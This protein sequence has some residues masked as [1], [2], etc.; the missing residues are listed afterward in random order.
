MRACP[1]AKTIAFA[2]GLGTCIFFKPKDGS[3]WQ[4]VGSTL[5]D[6]SST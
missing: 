2:T 3:E 1:K 4:P 5:K 6:I